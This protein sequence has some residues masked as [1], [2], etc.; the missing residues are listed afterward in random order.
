MKNGDATFL[1]E[2]LIFTNGMLNPWNVAFV[3]KIGTS[4]DSCFTMRGSLVVSKLISFQAQNL[5]ARSFQFLGKASQ[6]KGS[7]PTEANDNNVI[8]VVD[9]F[10]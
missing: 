10:V 9:L 8:H 6:G 3:F 4:I 1:F 5:L 2:G 7:Y